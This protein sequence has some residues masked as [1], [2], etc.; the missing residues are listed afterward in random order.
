MNPYGQRLSERLFVS[1][2]LA[3][4][5]LSLL[6]VWRTEDLRQLF[7][8]FFAGSALALTVSVP[9]WPFYNRTRLRWR[10]SAVEIAESAPLNLTKGASETFS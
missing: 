4:S 5:V 6:Q 2:L 1:I 10:Q 9:N 8:C 7:V 3:T